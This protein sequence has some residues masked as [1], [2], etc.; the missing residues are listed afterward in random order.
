VEPYERY[1]QDVLADTRGRATGA[2]FDFDG[3]I[4]ATHSIKDMFLERL[5]EGE[6]GVFEVI[7][8]SEMVSRYLLDVGGFEGALAAA[9]ENFAGVPEQHLADLGRKVGR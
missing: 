1:T 5:R 6:V 3:T 2:F 9:V 4:I 8:L 7:D